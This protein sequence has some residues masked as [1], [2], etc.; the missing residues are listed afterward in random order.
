ML[1]RQLQRQLQLQLQLHLQLLH[2]A[3]ESPSYV[4]RRSSSWNILKDEAVMKPLE[5]CTEALL[6]AGARG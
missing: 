2:H 5:L 6:G 4:T 1:Q 3:S